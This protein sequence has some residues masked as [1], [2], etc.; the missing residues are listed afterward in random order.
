VGATEPATQAQARQR[1]LTAVLDIARIVLTSLVLGLAQR[2]G[3]QPRSVT[4]ATLEVELRDAL[5]ALGAS[6]VSQL[7]RLR[8]TGSRG[9]SSVCP[10]GVRLVF[11]EYVSLAQRTWFG[12]VTIERA[13]YAGAGCTERAH[14]VP[15][16]AAWGLL[17]ALPVHDALPD[18]DGGTVAAVAPGAGTPRLAPA[19]AAVVVEFGARLPYAAAARLLAL[20]LG[21]VAH[22]APTTIRAYTEAAG[23]A[24]RQLE[25]AQ[26][27]RTQPPLRGERRAVLDTA[28]SVP[29]PAAAPAVLAISLDGAL[30]RTRTGWKEVKL[31]A[32]Y[33]LV[34][35]PVRQAAGVAAAGAAAG[36]AATLAVG[37]I[38]STATL[39]PA[40]DFGRQLLATAQRRGRRWAERVVVLGDGAKWIWKLAARRFPGAVEVVDWYHAG[41]HLWTLATLLYGE[42]RAAAWIWYET[43]RSVLW[44]IQ[45]EA[46][47]AV[48]AQAVAEAWTAAASLVEGEALPRRT[49]QREQ[50]V[51]KEVAYFASNAARLR[52]GHVREQGL[53]V[54]SGVVEGGCH[55]VLHVRLKC[56]GARWGV[57][58]AEHM[59]RTRAALC[60][61]PTPHCGHP[62]DRLAS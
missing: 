19:F 40:A 7:V 12:P 41:Q 9:H 45:T 15:L 24:R 32:V 48:V 47:V 46:E 21:A 44:D 42:G 18:P 37:A 34:T 29:R 38:T 22:L 33:D 13:V 1:A 6:L 25:D 11:K 14:H 56:P 43:L 53:P 35:R 10:C 58:S 27:V 4:L 51:A 57:E 5:L 60:S 16:D 39:A 30:E 54:G 61:A 23:R 28:G 26:R 62:Y 17:G 3:H 52:Y 20:A 55:S 8:G 36:A 49:K 2:L 59:V 31:G 50:A